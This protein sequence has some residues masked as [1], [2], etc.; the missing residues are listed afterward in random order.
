MLYI[1][2]N[3]FSFTWNNFKNL[4]TVTCIILYMIGKVKYPVT[5]A[6]CAS[7]M[8]HLPTSPEMDCQT[9]SMLA[10]PW[11][12]LQCPSLY[13]SL[14]NRGAV[15][16][17][18]STRAELLPDSVHLLALDVLIHYQSVRINSTSPATL[19]IIQPSNYSQ[20][21]RLKS[22]YLYLHL[23]Y[24]EQIWAFFYVLVCLNFI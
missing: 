23:H 8:Y 13:V 10:P 5:V 16:L 6:C 22:I 24:A 9:I 15:S 1:N 12:A 2:F 19:D 7:T 4:Y 18:C 11:G 20:P 14:T 3:H 21:K 17:G